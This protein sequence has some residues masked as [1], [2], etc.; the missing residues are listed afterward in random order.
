MLE[1]LVD[2]VNKEDMLMVIPTLWQVFA[3]KTGSEAV[4]SATKLLEDTM[5]RENEK[6]LT[7]DNFNYHLKR[8]QEESRITLKRM[9]FNIE[10]Y[11]GPFEGVLEEEIKRISDGLVLKNADK[12]RL[13]SNAEADAAENN[14]ANSLRDDMLPLSRKDLEAIADK[15]L[16]DELDSFEKTMKPFS[17]IENYSFKD[18]RKKLSNHLKGSIAI[19][20]EKNLE[21]IKAKVELGVIEAENHFKELEQFAILKNDSE[22]DQRRKELLKESKELFDKF[23]GSIKDE[24]ESKEAF[25]KLNKKLQEITKK[26]Y[27]NCIASIEK[28]GASV[29]GEAHLK[30]K[31][32]IGMISLPVEDDVLNNTFRRGEEEALSY[33]ETNM[34]KYSGSK[35]FAD[36]RKKLFDQMENLNTLTRNHNKEILKS[37]LLESKENGMYQLKKEVKDFWLVSSFKAHAKKVFSESIGEKIHSPRLKESVVEDFADEATTEFGSKLFKMSHIIAFLLLIIVLVV[38]VILLIIQRSI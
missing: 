25:E 27:K 9:V 4:R 34:S 31:G 22:F 21:A 11:Y 14:F 10:M 13:L 35:V 19:F 32:L 12:V 8:A 29:I 37:T 26:C 30:H 24:S 36:L 1:M 18:E 3:Q 7:R 17:T 16:K 15:L 33:F 2:A 38:V 20:R 5:A 23:V 6:A 28:Y